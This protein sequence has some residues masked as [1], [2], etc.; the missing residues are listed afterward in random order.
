M[1]RV[2]D[3]E[4]RKALA[5]FAQNSQL[6]ALLDAIGI[7]RF[8]TIALI[9]TLPA[10]AVIVEQGEIGSAFYLIAHGEVAILV[11]S[12]G[13]SPKE[14]ARLGAGNFFG[15]IAVLTRQPR[16]A[17]V[18]CTEPSTMIR[19]ERKQVLEI[20]EDYPKVKEVLGGVGRLRSEANLED[21]LGEGGGLADALEAP[22][23]DEVL[24]EEDAPAEMS[25]DDL[26]LSP[27]NNTP[28]PATPAVRAGSLDESDLFANGG[29]DD[30]AP[31]QEE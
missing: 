5:T 31:T 3:F 28:P 6:F 10:D 13:A 16:T 14:V 19:F 25:L 8:A 30:D 21:V 29:L 1:T 23:E 27:A 11:D 20:L 26:L 12:G 22:E 18:Q 15:E 7:H 17:T 24:P 9:E 4:V 2:A